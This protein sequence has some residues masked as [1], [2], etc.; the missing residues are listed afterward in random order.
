M[1]MKRINRFYVV[2]L[3]MV[4]LIIDVS[5]MIITHKIVSGDIVWIVIAFIMNVIAILASIEHHE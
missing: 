2:S 4:I 1:P 3:M 5:H